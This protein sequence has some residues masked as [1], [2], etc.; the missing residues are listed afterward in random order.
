MKQHSSEPYLNLAYAIMQKSKPTEDKTMTEVK[1]PPSLTPPA[2]NKAKPAAA[3]KAAE[4]TPPAKAAKPAKEPKPP[5]APKEPKESA[6]AG[7]PRPRK[8]EYG[9]KPDAFVHIVTEQAEAAKRAGVAKAYE[10][11]K[12]VV[13]ANEA[14]TGENST[15]ITVEEFYKRGGNRH[16]LRVMSR[17]GLIKIKWVTGEEFPQAA[18][19]KAPEPPKPSDAAPAPVVLT[20]SQTV[21][22][23][24]VG[25]VPAEV[26][27][28]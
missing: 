11:A 1:K 13:S 9:I 2:G 25:T 7:A 16:D 15:P 26:V 24:D 23:A 28:S 6:G 14:G 18:V 27:Q 17:R 19:P 22:S 4:T 10:F 21:T 5:K 3:Q 8:H 12:P 20:E